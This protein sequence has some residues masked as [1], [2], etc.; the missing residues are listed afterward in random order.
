[1]PVSKSLASM[2]NAEG[3]KVIM[4]EPVLEVSATLVAFTVTV[5]ALATAAGAVYNPVA[6]I[7]PTAG[8]TDH[9]T[10]VLAVFITVAV[11]CCV[12]PA[13]SVA[14]NGVTVTATAIP[15]RTIFATNAP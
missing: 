11:N 3:R 1:M 10:A 12:C 8:V 14:D 9:A 2:A 13:F 7:V 15:D 5:C 6:E 4:A